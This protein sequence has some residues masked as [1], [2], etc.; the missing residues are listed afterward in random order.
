MKLQ[1]REV[2]IARKQECM[3]DCA[4]VPHPTEQMMPWATEPVLDDAHK[5]CYNYML[6]W[7]LSSGQLNEPF[8][9]TSIAPGHIITVTNIKYLC[10]LIL[11]TD[12]SSSINKKV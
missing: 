1:V 2:L 8:F 10:N 5:W 12:T 11:T 6:H 3:C 7:T 9:V 4:Y